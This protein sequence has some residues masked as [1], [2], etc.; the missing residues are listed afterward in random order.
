MHRNA[1]SDKT[2]ILLLSV[3]QEQYKFSYDTRQPVKRNQRILL[4]FTRRRAQTLGKRTSA[5]NVC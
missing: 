5:L 2:L 1:H 4:F 3:H